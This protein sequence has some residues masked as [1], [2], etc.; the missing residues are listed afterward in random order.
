MRSH[1][2]LKTTGLDTLHYTSIISDKILSSLS[3]KNHEIKRG[4][5]VMVREC[6]EGLWNDNDS[7]F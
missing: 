7:W 2:I 6:M 1:S 3:G 5:K 4:R